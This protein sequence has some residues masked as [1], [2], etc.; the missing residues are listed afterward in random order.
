MLSNLSKPFSPSWL[1][2]SGRC[3]WNDSVN[4]IEGAETW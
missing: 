4:R 2:S 3:L 1:L